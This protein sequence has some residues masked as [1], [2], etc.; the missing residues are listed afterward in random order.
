MVRA[1]LPV[2]VV[3]FV[4]ACSGGDERPAR[5]TEPAAFE[6]VQL[7]AGIAWRAPEP[8]LGRRPSSDMRTAE[9]AV[10]GHEDAELVVFHF[11]AENERGEEVAEGG[12]VEENVGRWLDQFAQP[13]G[14]ASRDVAEIDEREIEGLEVTTVAVTGTFSGLR[15][16]G[17]E[18]SSENYALRGAIVEA[19]DGLVFFKLLGPRASVEA[20]SA[21][22]DA[23]LDSIRVV[24][25]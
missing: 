23:L 5:T 16:T 1:A 25:D 24:N 2:F 4:L 9:Y 13:D 15:G 12:S 18:D 11:R 7:V 3:S 22:F 21:G 19:P 17:A 20:A 14:R 10:R 6:P 8:F